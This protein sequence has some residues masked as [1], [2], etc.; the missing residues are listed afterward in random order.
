MLK[1]IVS[2]GLEKGDRMEPF[3]SLR[4][5]SLLESAQ[6]FPLRLVFWRMARET[7]TRHS[8]PLLLGARGV[9]IRSFRQD[10]LHGLYTSAL[11]W[12]FVVLFYGFL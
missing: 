10:L 5:V 9:S 4:D 1:D 12:F 2:L 3:E 8:N 7:R 6:R 11:G